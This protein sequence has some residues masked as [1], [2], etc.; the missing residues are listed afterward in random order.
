MRNRPTGSQFLNCAKFPPGPIWVGQFSVGRFLGGFRLRR[1]GLATLGRRGQVPRVP[2]PCACL[3]PPRT[4]A[5][6]AT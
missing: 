6:W 5:V 3:W 1:R 4:V 2:Q